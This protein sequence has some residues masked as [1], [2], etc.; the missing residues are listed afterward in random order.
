MSRK[1][2]P[3]LRATGS[4]RVSGSLLSAFFLVLLQA[5]PSPAATTVGPLAPMTI[6]DSLAYKT[7]RAC[8]ANCLVYNG[9]FACGVNRGYYDLG[10]FLACPCG[11]S[12]AC[13]CSKPL[14]SSA[15]SYIQSCV[16]AGC[17]KSVADWPAE[18]SNMLNLYDGYCATANVLAVE[19]PATTTPPAVTTTATTAPG[20]TPTS[21]GNGR[22][23]PGA[24]SNGGTSTQASVLPGS[25]ST[26]S[27]EVGKGGLSQ[28][29]IVALAASLGVGIPSLLV[30]GATLCVM[31]RKRKRARA[32]AAKPGVQYQMPP[33]NYSPQAQLQAQS[34]ISEMDGGARYPNQGFYHH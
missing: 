22:T 7:A 32:E 16:S 34:H 26:Q 15:T 6:Y 21:T 13:Y 27:T 30:A 4:G 28:S 11:P 23:S 5:T 14:G 18:V 29:D 2:L 25:T 8:A 17:G 10:V 33:Q 3:C 31:L 9:P 12:N 19:V 20:T 24:V 1:P